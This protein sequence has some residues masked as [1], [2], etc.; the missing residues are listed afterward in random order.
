MTLA[1]K[2]KFKDCTR[3]AAHCLNLLAEAT[4]PKAR[5]L[6]RAMVAE[7]LMLANAMRPPRKSWQIIQSSRK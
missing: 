1:E 2:D 6:R 3:Y 4:D 5:S 7:W